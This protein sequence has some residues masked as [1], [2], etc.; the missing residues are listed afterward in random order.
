MKTIKTPE[1]LLLNCEHDGSFVPVSEIV[2]L[3][4][5]YAAQLELT[6]EE[7]DKQADLKFDTFYTKGLWIGGA[8]W[9][10]SQIKELQNKENKKL[11]PCGYKGCENPHEK[12][13]RGCDECRFNKEIQK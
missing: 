4:K 2:R 10:R 12:V 5:A 8:K 7:I 1:E 9:Y 13:Y 6:D 11:N 3:I